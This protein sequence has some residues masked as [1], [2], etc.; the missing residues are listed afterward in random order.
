MRS[1]FKHPACHGAILALLCFLS[2][3]PALSRYFVS[4]DFF[5]LRRLAASSLWDTTWTHLTGPLLEISFVKF[6]RP[7]AGFLLHVESLL[8]GAA[9]SG[10]LITH[11]LIHLLNV[12]L[13]YQ[14]AKIWSSQGTA[15]RDDSG[16]DAGSAGTAPTGRTAL[17]VSAIFA[18]YPLHPNA[19]LFVAGFA[20]IYSALFLLTTLVLYERY[21]AIGNVRTLWAAAGCFMLALGSYEQTVILPG[22]L[23]ARELLAAWDRRDLGRWRKLIR[24]LAPTGPFFVLLAL[25][26]VVRQAALD[27]MVAGYDGF[28]ERLLSEEAM[29]L[30]HSM[31]SGIARLVYPQ[32]GHEIGAAMLWSVGLVLLVGS[33]WVVKSGAV[34]RR[35]WILGWLWILASQAPF[36]F[37]LVVP[38]NG[39]YWYLTSIGLGLV[40]VASGRLLASLVVRL[41]WLHS[42]GRDR[43]RPAL[44][45][46]VSAILLVVFALVYLAQLRH[47][48]RIYAEAGR[49][50]HEIQKQLAELPAGQ[51]VFVAG[52][53]DFLR[54]LRQVPIAQVYSWGL[55]DALASPFVARGPIVYPLPRV[56]DGELLPV[57]ERTDLAAT[58]RWHSETQQLERVPRSAAV[59]AASPTRLAVERDAGGGL[60]FQAAAGG[61][62]L[63]LLTRGS[64]STYPIREPA[65]PDGWTHVPLPEPVINSMHHL[66]G[67]EIY[68]WVE[69]RQDGRQIAVSRLE[70]ITPGS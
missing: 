1:L 8:W 40:I 52:V 21:R 53:P 48:V 18:L 59:A 60:R 15:S 23:A 29:K 62:Y 27:Q 42:G 31:L 24:Q 9:P 47:Y 34:E 3:G 13:V 7:V 37:A 11:L 25:Y 63:V 65:G 10:Y 30:A 22:L 45:E 12:A 43:V 44:T 6:Y 58:W 46:S 56:D 32:Y 36:A 16:A 54:G 33:L 28:R 49:T 61:H 20:T 66:Y 69:A 41:P 39:R 26:F 51:A 67:G 64:A 35:L 2:Y 68:A 17:G 14:L 55:N 5:V 57:L 19:V 38:G 50:T 70:R 4:E